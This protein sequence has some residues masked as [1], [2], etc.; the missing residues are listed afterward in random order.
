MRRHP[1]LAMFSRRLSC[2]TIRSE[3]SRTMRSRSC[4][5][6]TYQPRDEDYEAFVV[7]PVPWPR[8]SFQENR[9]IGA[10]HVSFHQEGDF[11]HI[12]KIDPDPVMTS[13]S[14]TY[15]NEDQMLGTWCAKAPAV[16]K[17]I[18]AAID[19]ARVARSR[20]STR[21][22]TG[23]RREDSLYFALSSPSMAP[24]S[25]LL[26]AHAE[27]VLEKRFLLRDD[28]G[29]LR[30]G[31]ADAVPTRSRAPSPV[32]MI[33]MSDLS[34]AAA[35]EEAFFDAMTSLRF[36]PNSPTLMNAGV[37]RGQL[38]RLFC[39]PARRLDGLDLRHAARRRAR[40]EERRRHWVF[41]FGPTAQGRGYI[42]S[43]R[44]ASS[45]PGIVHAALRLLDAGQPA[46]RHARRREHGGAA[47]RSP[48][49]PRVRQREA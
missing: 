33:T 15:A 16:G 36:L 28:T 21:T 24:Q 14:Y 18:Q 8:R 39:A 1:A 27:T 44:G 29:V 31:C 45:G 6:A 9:V 38:R 2:S 20:D 11:E 42:R 35:S 23:I 32:S 5:R 17:A 12:W 30:R 46:R 49:H 3:R 13:P 4:C 19:R 47:A 22:C 7:F 40:A 41:V 34:R 26:S 48:R 25:V 43:T 10:I 37:A